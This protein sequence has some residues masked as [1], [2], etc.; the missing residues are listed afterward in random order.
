MGTGRTDE[1][2]KDAGSDKELA[3]KMSAIFTALD[4]D[5]NYMLTKEEINQ[6]NSTDLRVIFGLRD[7]DN[8][9][10]LSLEEQTGLTSGSIFPS[11]MSRIS[12]RIASIASQKR[13]NSALVSVS[14]GSTISV[15][16]TGQLIVGA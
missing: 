16:A 13:S 9:G 6:Q 7:L 3:S 5:K 14:V 12:S 10:R 4:E 2:R 8:D 11:S 15:P 1:F